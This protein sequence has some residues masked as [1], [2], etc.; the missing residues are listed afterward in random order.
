MT[1]VEAAGVSTPIIRVH[2][3]LAV[4]GADTMDGE[5]L[6]S[7]TI[8]PPDSPVTIGSVLRF[9][10]IHTRMKTMRGESGKYSQ[11][12]PMPRDPTQKPS[13][14]PIIH[15]HAIS[16][17]LRQEYPFL[18]CT[19]GTQRSVDRGGRA[20]Y[21]GREGGNGDAAAR[22]DSDQ[23]KIDKR[24]I[25]TQAMPRLPPV[26]PEPSSG[27][28][29]TG[30]IRSGLNR[31][32]FAVCAPAETCRD[33]VLVP[34]VF[35]FI[36]GRVWHSLAR[37]VGHGTEVCTRAKRLHDEVD[38]TKMC[39]RYQHCR[40]QLDACIA[41]SSTRTVSDLVSTSCGLPDGFSDGFFVPP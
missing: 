21:S 20:R 4:I 37:G 13:D 27:R 38:A 15:H 35:S 25:V 6:I 24:P 22:A 1:E 3:A 36:R 19:E 34:T 17:I 7:V 14:P 10:E 11:Q 30:S 29:D 40:T 31:H 5:G 12:R 33:A 16:D 2:L 8:H 9:P 41:H 28:V 18:G 32:H 26:T 39:P 23:C